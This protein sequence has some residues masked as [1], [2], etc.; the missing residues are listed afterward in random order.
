VGG[1]LNPPVFAPWKASVPGVVFRTR[2]NQID[3]WQGLACNRRSLMHSTWIDLTD[4]K[5]HG[6]KET[7]TN[8]E[9]DLSS[10]PRHWPCSLQH[11]WRVGPGCKRQR[12]DGPAP[13]RTLRRVPGHT[14]RPLSDLRWRALRLNADS[15]VRREFATMPGLRDRQDRR[16]G[17]RAFNTRGHANPLARR[18]RMAD[19][20]PRS[21]GH[22]SAF[23]T[24]G[25]IRSGFVTAAM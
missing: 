21:K 17:A 4:G 10:L 18:P 11:L 5:T 25:L 16:P 20:S 2:Q 3:F 15:R 19:P 7:A 1:V 23:F 8:P 13:V 12:R 22:S 14:N 9:A 24:N 6:P